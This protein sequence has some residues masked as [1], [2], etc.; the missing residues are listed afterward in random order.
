M[1]PVTSDDELQRLRFADDGDVYNDFSRNGRSGST[2][3]VLHRA[4]CRTLLGA[5]TRPDKYVATDLETA[6]RWLF[7]NRR[8]NWKRCECCPL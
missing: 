3:N 8:G 7:A 2:Y 6:E 5:N 1:Q 4:S